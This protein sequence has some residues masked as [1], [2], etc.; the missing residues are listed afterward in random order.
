MSTYL[1]TGTIVTREP[2]AYCPPDHRGADRVARLP[3]MPVPS[4]AGPMDTVYLSGSTIRGAYRHA[5][6]DVWLE[7]EGQVSVGRYLEVKVGG[8]KGSGEEPRVGLSE[9]AA[10]LEAEPFLSLFGAGASPIGWIH[11]RLEVGAALPDEPVQPVRFN[12]AR[13]DATAD[14]MLLEVVDADGY[15]AVLDGHAANRRRS[16]AAAEMRALEQRIRKARR[17]R[18]DTA[19]LERALDAAR[20]TEREA[21]E[22]QSAL[23]GSDVS[24]RQPLPGYE[25]IP[26]GTVLSHRMMASH[27]TEGQMALLMGGL[28]RFAEAPRFGAHRAHGCGRVRIAYEV[29]RLEG[30]R[31]H[32][33]GTVT[34]D[35]ERWDTEG[36]SLELS[37]APERWLRAWEAGAR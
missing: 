14:P 19:E 20:Q 9:R 26:P 5:C 30:T 2:L 21:A 34:I 7:R 12:G 37:G 33:T 29:K 35:P 28:A 11:S 17:S 1:F 8:V 10:Y 36:S 23:L 31:A 32:A 15:A 24:L 27:V 13:G 6:A 16:Q 4:T 18:Q 22:A 25:A 3:Q